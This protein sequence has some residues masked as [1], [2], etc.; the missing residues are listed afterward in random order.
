MF[1]NVVGWVGAILILMAYGLLSFELIQQTDW[2]YHLINLIGSVG[3]ATDCMID[4]SYPAAVM[5]VIFTAVAI[6]ALFRFMNRIPKPNV[7]EV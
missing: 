4:G 5:N 1:G 7:E 3:L 6:Y 2:R